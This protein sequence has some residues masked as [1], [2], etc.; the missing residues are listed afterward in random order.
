MRGACRTLGRR[1]A[2][3]GHDSGRLDAGPDV[4][5]IHRRC[6]ARVPV[7]WPTRFPASRDLRF[8][9][10]STSHLPA[11]PRLRTGMRRSE[12]AQPPS[13]GAR[14]VTHWSRDS[15][16]AERLRAGRNSRASYHRGFGRCSRTGCSDSQSG[17]IGPRRGIQ[18]FRSRLG[19]AEAGRLSCRSL[20]VL[21]SAPIFCSKCATSL[22]NKEQ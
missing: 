4:V 17:R 14:R 19:R 8:G 10:A 5:A 1:G 13:C 15:T 20:S 3:D 16:A 18:Q 22:T 7:V 11:C 9:S 6:L 21:P 2:D 12:L